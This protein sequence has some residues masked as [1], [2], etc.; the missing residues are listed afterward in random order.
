MNKKILLFAVVIF[1]ILVVFLY[2]KDSFF[3][4]KKIVVLALDGLEWNIINPLL[5]KGKLPN[6]KKLMDEGVYTELESIYPM[7]SPVIWTTIATGC[8]PAK[9]GILDYM[10]AG[11]TVTSKIRKGDALWNV[12]SD[13]NKTVGFIGYFVTWPAEEVNGYIISDQTHHALLRKEIKAEDINNKELIFP[14][15]ILNPFILEKQKH[16]NFNLS[17]ELL[18][19]MNYTYK[20]DFKKTFK[21]GTDDFFYNFLIEKRLAQVYKRDMTYLKIAEFLLKTRE[22]PDLLGIYL[23]GVDFTSHAFWRYYDPEAD[24]FYFKK[25]VTQKEKNMFGKVIPNYYIFFDKYIGKLKALIDK[26]SNII[27]LSDH[28]FMRNPKAGHPAFWYLTGNHRL[29]GVFIAHGPDFKRTGHID[30]L[31]IYDIAPLIYYLQGIP[32]PDYLVS[33]VPKNIVVE[34]IKISQKKKGKEEKK[35]IKPESVKSVFEEDIKDELRA[36]GY[37]DGQEYASKSTDDSDLDGIPDKSDNCLY[38]PNPKQED[39]DEDGIGDFC[40]NCPYVSNPS[41][42]DYDQNG[43]GDV[44]DC[45]DLDRDGYGN[46]VFPNTCEEDNCPDNYNPGQEDTYPPGGNGIGDACECEGDFD[47]DGDVDE[48]D[49]ALFKADFGRNQYKNPCTNDNPCNGD[50]DCDGDVDWSDAEI[51]KSDFGRNA[52]KNPCPPCAGGNWCVY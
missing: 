1:T 46:A 32:R 47:C 12:F 27:I 26:N 49:A 9:H 37:I 31:S 23:R 52:L 2:V 19:F 28:G 33:S 22:Q 3:N 14:K 42:D 7:S 39:T 51:F 41:Q 17:L 29:E 13:Y 36:L 44:C 38:L 45:P 18:Q 16:L 48:T 6:I 43:I 8:Q 20:H 34:G 30:R 50:F 4:Y 21:K 24:Y 10:K 15:G 5:E 25:P 35:E 40:D 11:I